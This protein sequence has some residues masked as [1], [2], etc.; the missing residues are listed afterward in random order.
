MDR[1]RDL[2]RQLTPPDGVGLLGVPRILLSA[3]G[4]S[5]VYTYVRFLDELYLVDGLR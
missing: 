4:R 2:Y 1:A 3:D 5:Y